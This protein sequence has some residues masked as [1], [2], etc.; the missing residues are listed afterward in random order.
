LERNSPVSLVRIKVSPQ[1]VQNRALDLEE[2]SSILAN[3]VGSDDLQN[4]PFL[5]PS[6]SNC[7]VPVFDLLLQRA[8]VRIQIVILINLELELK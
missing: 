2:V 4:N 3:W 7:R 8:S 1:F 5:I 6:R